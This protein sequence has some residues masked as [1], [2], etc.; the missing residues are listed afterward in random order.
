MT[1]KFKSISSLFTNKPLFYINLIISVLAIIFLI[2]SLFDPEKYYWSLITGIVLVVIA[3]FI[4]TWLAWKTNTK[5]S[6]DDIWP[7]GFSPSIK[8]LN[9]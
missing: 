7:R 6:I 2:V 4:N 8:N 5:K 1:E 3:L 9:S